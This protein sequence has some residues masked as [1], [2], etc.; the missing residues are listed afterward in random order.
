MKTPDSL[1]MA[2][3]VSSA[4][5]FDS[6]G[7][8]MVS[9]DTSTSV[10]THEAALRNGPVETARAVHFLAPNEVR[11]SGNQEGTFYA[12]SLYW[13][14]ENHELYFKG[15]VMVDV[16]DNSFVSSGSVTFLGKVY[17]LVIDDSIVKLDS[18]IKLS[19][20]Q[21][22]LKQLNNGEATKKYGEKGENGAVE[23]NVIE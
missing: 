20:R 7:Q 8:S 3:L 6:A 5:V 9:V 13:S 15:K 18:T 22:R 16:G 12:T 23:I 19:Q 10:E 21:Y 11:E 1:G 4:L 2:L 14:S 17:L